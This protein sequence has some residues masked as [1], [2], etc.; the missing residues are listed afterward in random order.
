MAIRVRGSSFQVDFVHGGVR[1]RRDKPTLQEAEACEITAKANLIRGLNPFPDEEV[2][3]EDK[4]PTFRVVAE[5]VWDLVWQHQKSAAK[6]RSRLN[7][8]LQDMDDDPLV[9]DIRM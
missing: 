6:T 9:A 4:G 7:I 3:V 8:V 2:K 1:Y 5:Q